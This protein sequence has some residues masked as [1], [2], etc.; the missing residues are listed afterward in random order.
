MADSLGF[1]GAG[2]WRAKRA[3]VDYIVLIARE[4]RIARRIQTVR[5]IDSNGSHRSAVANAEA[6]CV[7]HVVKV[8]GAALAKSE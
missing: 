4:A 7:H 3:A 2:L 5:E 8:R 1:R 6:S